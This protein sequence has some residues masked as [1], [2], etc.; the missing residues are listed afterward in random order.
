MIIKEATFISSNTTVAKCPETELPEYAFIGRSNVG[1]SSLINMLTNRSKLAKT[2]SF[3][4]KTQL[5]NHFKINDNWFLVDL[6]GYGWAKVS[7]ESRDKWQKMI[8]AYLQ[9]RK[10]LA[11]VFLLIDSRHEPQQSDLEF[12]QLLGTLGVPFVLVFTKTDKQSLNKTQEAVAAYKKKLL[13]TWEELP[14]MFLTSSE[15]K[16]GRDEILDFIE[17]VNTELN[18]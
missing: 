18:K 11:C 4:G 7:K 17:S 1:K 14:Q 3:P 16:K 8:K 12:I 13:E 10:N 2:S 6:P 5:I 15:E 9:Q